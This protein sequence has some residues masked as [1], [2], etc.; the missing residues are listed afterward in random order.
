[1]AVGSSGV[2][3]DRGE[4]TQSHRFGEGDNLLIF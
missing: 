1:M 3:V 4:C 2:H